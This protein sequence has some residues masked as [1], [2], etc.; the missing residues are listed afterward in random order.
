MWDER[1]HKNREIGDGGSR[2]L[3]VEPAPSMVESFAFGLAFMYGAKVEDDL[4]GRIGVFCPTPVQ[5]EPLIT[6]NIGGL[7]KAVERIKSGD[8]G[9]CIGCCH[10]LGQL[11]VGGVVKG[12][13]ESRA[14]WWV[15]QF[16]LTFRRGSWNCFG[17]WEDAIEIVWIV[18]LSQR[19]HGHISG[20][21]AGSNPDDVVIEGTTGSSCSLDRSWKEGRSS[22]VQAARGAK[23]NET[24]AG[25]EMTY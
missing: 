23:L 25:H 10:V 11:A 3:V 6:L 21:L 12:G 17:R 13:D 18:Q 20:R 9:R 14:F 15:S 16:L 22:G 24:P 8:E 19:R 1:V 7:G 4:D 2:M 5:Q